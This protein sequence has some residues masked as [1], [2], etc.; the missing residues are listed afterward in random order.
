MSKEKSRHQVVVFIAEW[1]PHCKNMQD[2]VWTDENVLRA[3]SPYHGGSPAF[4]VCSKPQNRYL[5]DEFNLSRY[6]TV[7]IMDENHNVKKTAYNMP[8]NEVVDFLENLDVS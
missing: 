4:I 5:V 6:P 1:C 8:P 7:V 3:V 2:N